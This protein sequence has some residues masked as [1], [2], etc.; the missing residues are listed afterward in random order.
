M[1]H[2]I[3]ETP[4]DYDHTRIIE[5]PDGCYWTD[6]ESGRRFGYGVFHDAS[7]VP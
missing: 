5:R 1:K 6:A 2:A 4:A 7:S 3:P